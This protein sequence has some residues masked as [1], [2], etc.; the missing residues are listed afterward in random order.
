M[1]W[2]LLSDPR[3]KCRDTELFN[4]KLRPVA[5]RSAGTNCFSACDI[6]MHCANRITY[7]TVT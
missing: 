2:N 3:N 1:S 7:E 6:H 5:D 4:Q